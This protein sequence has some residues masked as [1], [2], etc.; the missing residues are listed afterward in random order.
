M[1]EWMLMPLKRYADFSGR[2]RRKEFW[3]F[4]LLNIIV[5]AVFLGPI[6]RSMIG[7]MMSQMAVAQD[8][9]YAA[10]ASSGFQYGDHP[11]AVAFAAIGV[12]WALFVLIPGIAVT[13]RRL[14]DRDMSGWW[15]LGFV[16]L[17]LIPLIG[18]VA[19]IAFIV[20]MCLD[21]TKGTNRFGADPK[22]G[23]T[24]PEVFN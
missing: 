15:Y 1:L 18:I 19:S 23:G 8:G 11:I 16:V 24:N 10:A 6:Y 2:S 5:T 7:S 20:V 21:G 4:Q 14:H 17:A 3:L 22:G 9:T 13:V 12:I